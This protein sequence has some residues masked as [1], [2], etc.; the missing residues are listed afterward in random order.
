MLV[1]HFCLMLSFNRSSSLFR[2]GLL[3][4]HVHL[5]KQHMSLKVCHGLWYPVD[6]HSFSKIEPVFSKS[7]FQYFSYSVCFL[8]RI[9]FVCF[10][11]CIVLGTCHNSMSH[12]IPNC[13]YLFCLNTGA[14]EKYFS[15][16]IPW[17]SKKVWGGHYPM[18]DIGLEGFSPHRSYDRYS[19]KSQFSLGFYP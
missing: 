16:L 13:L 2:L 17:W 6:Q 15:I 5:D 12:N 4:V 14:I 9:R 7:Y 8:L 19:S 11:I 1:G 10:V 3:S 18:P